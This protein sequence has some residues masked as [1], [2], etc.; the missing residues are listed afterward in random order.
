MVV[1]AADTKTIESLKRKFELAERNQRK[2]A[3]QWRKNGR[4]YRCETKDKNSPGDR[5]DSKLYVPYAENQIDIIKVRLVEPN[6]D[7]EYIPTEP[8]DAQKTK[9]LSILR[10][11]HR[12]RDNY[13]KK[14]DD[15]VHDALIYQMAVAKV[16]WKHKT[17]LQRVK[18]KLNMLQRVANVPETEV[19]EVVEYDQPTA[20]VVDPFDFFWDPSATNDEDWEFVFHRIWLS[21]EQ[22]LDRQKRGIYKNVDELIALQEKGEFDS[23]RSDFETEEEQNARRRD[24]FEIIEYWTPTKLCVLGER[25]VLLRETDNPFWHG[26]IPFVTGCTQPR[27]RSLVGRSEVEQIE[28]LQ[29]FAHTID[30]LRIAGAKVAIN[31]PFKYRRGMKGGKDFKIL[32]GGRLGV[33]RMDDIEQLIVNPGT[34]FGVEEG[35][36]LLGQM[37]NQTGANSYLSGSDSA[38]SQISQDTATGVSLLQQE[39]NKRMSSKMLYMQLFHAR[40]EKL[41]VQLE[42]QFLSEKQRIRVVGA[43]GD[44]WFEVDPQEVLGEYDVEP[45]WSSLEMNKMNERQSAIELINTLSQGLGQPLA[46][47]TTV[48]LK[49]AYKRL[50]ESFDEDSSPYFTDYKQMVQMELEAELMQEEAR[51]QMEMRQM[52]EQQY[53]IQPQPEAPVAA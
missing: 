35:Q 26:K 31:P 6:P 33:D 10:R 14:Q 25:S 28:A 15:W 53:L 48:S 23:F 5:K 1:A 21:K 12:R 30:N 11:Y 8:T 16:S 45:K 42:Q 20:T 46:D 24:K 3:D 43:A 44:E 36:I 18:R 13:V 9:S 41:C 39:A 7:F 50:V 49:H 29:T 52:A 2:Y 4:T 47:G 51:G 38:M 32:P 34:A 27:P 19:R 22:L 17:R 40:I 37:Q